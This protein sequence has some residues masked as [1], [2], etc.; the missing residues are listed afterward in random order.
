MASQPS[1][2]GLVTG[3]S[4]PGITG[5]GQGGPAS[6]RGEAPAGGQQ[7]AEFVPGATPEG[8]QGLD[9]QETETE[10]FEFAGQ[11]FASR[12]AAEQ[13][14]RTALGRYRTAQSEAS[15][16]QQR[17]VELERTAREAAS[18]AHAWEQHATRGQRQEKPQA[19]QPQEPEKPW[20]DD[21]DYDFA[22]EIAEQRGIGN[23]FYWAMQ[24][25]DQHYSGLLEQKLNQRLAPHEQRSQQSQMYEQT[26]GT[27]NQVAYQADEGGNLLF[28]ELHDQVM[29]ADVVRIWATLDKSIALTP[30]GV[31]LAVL[32]YRHQNGQLRNGQIGAPPSPAGANG[33]SQ[34][35]LRG[36]QRS[37][38]AS[39]EVLSGNGTPRAA[40][41]GTPGAS[42]FK[43]HRRGL[44]HSETQGLRPRFQSFVTL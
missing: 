16:L 12:E 40:T 30:R 1:V 29:A 2:P 41:P 13:E 39:S 5:P 32:E 28:P 10:S 37:A 20:Y 18:L 19:S 25:M 31:M 38:Q 4:G 33:A 34:G 3:D 21:L 9:E 44:A 36:A 7:G 24:Q 43:Q 42:T 8:P 27:F 14:V 26:M 11:T 22:K 15:K 6:G 17:V 35:V 23:A